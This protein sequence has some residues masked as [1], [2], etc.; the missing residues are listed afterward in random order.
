MRL[1]GKIAFSTTSSCSQSTRC[2]RLTPPKA[3]A[4]CI[5]VVL[6]RGFRTGL[7]CPVG[8]ILAT[9]YFMRSCVM[10]REARHWAILP[11][12]FTLARHENR[13]YE[14]FSGLFLSLSPLN[15][16]NRV[17]RAY[18]AFLGLYSILPHPSTNYF[19]GLVALQEK[20]RATKASS[21]WEEETRTIFFSFPDSAVY[22]LLSRAVLLGA[23]FCYLHSNTVT[24]STG[25][26]FYTSN[27]VFTRT[28]IFISRA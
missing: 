28:H 9:G 19:L 24:K 13:A 22:A 25:V 27:C 3:G 4:G 2:N 10:E 18:G 21:I 1:F 12:S 23:P 16:L 14:A 7:F 20:S 6:K 5:R 8:W 17:K 26:D 15:R 11:R